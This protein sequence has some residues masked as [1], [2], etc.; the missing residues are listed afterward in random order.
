MRRL[1]VVG[2]AALSVLLYGA[3]GQAQAVEGVVLIDQ[4][5]ALAGD[6]TPG[7]SRVFPITVTQAG[8]YRLASH[9]LVPDANTT[10]IEI[11]ARNVT[12][13]LNG[14]S[15][16]GP[17]RYAKSPTGAICV[18]FS[19]SATTGYGVLH[20]PPFDTTLNDY[21]P[22]DVVV[23]NGSVFGMGNSG[24]VLSGTD[25]KVAHVHA[26][27]NAGN[28]LVVYDGEIT[29]GQASRNCGIGINVFHG[30]VSFNVSSYNLM[31]GIRIDYEA[32]VTSNTSFL[33]GA[34]GLRILGSG[35]P[36]FDGGYGNN[37]FFTNAGGAVTGGTSLGHNLCDARP[38]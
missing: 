16:I 21:P 9:L 24:I 19:T 25:N 3:V 10:A 14:F 28:G 34:Q 26:H 18:P 32:L 31:E 27:D 11:T 5:R 8:S 29:H 17:T 2:F 23:R 35:V 36:I 33:N 4:A 15:V 6:V 13:D 12:L 30:L 20:S 37:V 22:S 38:C 7:D 1:L